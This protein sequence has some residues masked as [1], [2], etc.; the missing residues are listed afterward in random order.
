[1]LMGHCV[2]LVGSMLPVFWDFLF[3][4]QGPGGPEE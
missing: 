1:V 4:L 2:P 3:N